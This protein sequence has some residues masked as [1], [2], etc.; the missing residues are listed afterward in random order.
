MSISD[1]W[2]TNIFTSTSCLR[3]QDAATVEPCLQYLS[4]LE[5]QLRL[6]LIESDQWSIPPQHNAPGWI[7]FLTQY[8]IRMQQHHENT[9][10]YGLATSS[11]N[12]NRMHI[13]P[14]TSTDFSVRAPNTGFNLDCRRILIRILTHQSEC[15]ALKATSL[16]RSKQWKEG[17]NQYTMALERI[18]TALGVADTQISK[19]MMVESTGEGF[20]SHLH[21]SKQE[22]I[23]DADIVAIAIESLTIGRERFIQL[24]KKEEAALLRQLE[25]QWEARDEV[26]RRIGEHRWR[27]NSRPKNDYAKMRKDLEKMYRD[28]RD[29]LKVLE[30]MDVI[31][32]QAR[33]KSMDLKSQLDGNNVQAEVAQL[34]Q[35]YNGLRPD[36]SALENR[37]SLIDYPDPTDFNWIFTG[38][39]GVTEFFEKDNAKLDWFF[40]T[41]TMKTSLEH[42]TQGKT[43]MYRKNVNPS[44][45]RKILEN[46]RTHTKQGYQRRPN[47]RRQGTTRN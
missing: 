11:P 32:I 39:S 16:Q 36:A 27:N 47:G 37:V 3:R 20:T 19:W 18:H 31:L 12:S 25:P 6:P 21:S 2:T 29:A 46:P 28:V 14:T 23:E 41:A 40:T 9:N 44:L 35:R 26:K 33:D 42:P 7:P 30:N 5:A 22:L 38:S 8:E 45:Y 15:L 17:A 4:Y 10:G 24:G 34:Q 1:S 13:P 43:Q